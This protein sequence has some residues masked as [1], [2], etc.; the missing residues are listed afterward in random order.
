MIVRGD[1]FPRGISAYESTVIS[2]CAPKTYE[3]HLLRLIDVDVNV[4]LLYG[5]SSSDDYLVGVDLKTVQPPH[6]L[7]TCVDH[8]INF[9]L[10]CTF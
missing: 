10:F 9:S 7:V 4:F 8:N 3:W 1:N 6:H 5:N 2:D